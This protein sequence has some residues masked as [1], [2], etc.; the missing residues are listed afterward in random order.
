MHAL[1][2]ET[3]EGLTLKQ[4]FQVIWTFGLLL[5]TAVTKTNES[6]FGSFVTCGLFHYFNLFL[7]EEA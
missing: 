7:K 4:V 2:R 1:M 6:K 5:F 3:D